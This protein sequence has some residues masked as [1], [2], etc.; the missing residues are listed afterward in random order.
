MTIPL[1]PTF[2]PN[3][4]AEALEALERV[5]TVDPY[6]ILAGGVLRDSLFGKEVKDVDIFVGP[7]FGIM[8][9]QAVFQDEAVSVE[10]DVTSINNR[11]PSYGK[12][13]GEQVEM[14]FRVE[15]WDYFAQKR[16]IQIIVRRDPIILDGVLADFDW[17]FCQ[18]CKWNAIKNGMCY[19]THN[20]RL[21]MN[22]G[23]VFNTLPLDDKR[24]PHSLE[25]GR[26]L[27]AK[28][29]ERAFYTQQDYRTVEAWEL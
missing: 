10:F 23:P 2:V 21:S 27:S 19:A 11:D 24:M 16:P 29:P 15:P 13:F 26:R 8:D 20:F 5:Q 7:G 28:Y 4:P 12:G 6:A 14:V 1:Y 22:D 18:I 3:I 25:R 9:L 17:S